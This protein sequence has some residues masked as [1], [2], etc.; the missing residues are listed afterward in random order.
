MTRRFT[1]EEVKE[2]IEE[3]GCKLIS[4]EYKNGRE[5]L[6]IECKCGNIFSQNFKNFKN[7]M[8]YSC[9]R[10]NYHSLSYNEVK[11]DIEVHGG[12]LLSDIYINNETKLDVKCG[13]GNIFSAMYRDIKSKSRY[14][15]P[16]CN[17]RP[18]LTFDEV[19][20]FI[21][22]K[23]CELL[24]DTYINNNIPI[25]IK[26]KCGVVFSRR[27]NNFK[28]SESYYCNHC[29]KNMSKGEYK[30]EEY[31]IKNNITYRKQYRFTDCKFHRRLSFDFAIFKDDKLVYLIE[32]D[33][34]QHYEIIRAFG[35]LDGFI[36][37]KIRDTIKNEYC[38]NNN[39]KLI[40]IPFTEI[41]NIENILRQVDTEVRY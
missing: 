33:G 30:I 39:I 21:S 31:L 6:D 5:K 2:F 12:T 22:S 7:T 1:Y 40:R 34:R 16:K 23:G 3:K 38:K 25:K 36:D 28:D 24:S 41:N 32:Y 15:C 14:N 10:C 9:P 20:S 17:N 4:K 11:N 35:G 29:S 8:K 27:F 37:G 26:C 18:N 19:K 13:C